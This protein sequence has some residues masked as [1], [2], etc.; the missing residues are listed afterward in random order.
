[1]TLINGRAKSAADKPEITANAT[2]FV[3][4]NRPVTYRMPRQGPKADPTPAVDNT[5]GPGVSSN[6][7]TAVAN[8]SIVQ[9]S[10]LGVLG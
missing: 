4:K 2:A 5:P 1:M 7:K 6:K 8:V 10:P 9:S 3:P